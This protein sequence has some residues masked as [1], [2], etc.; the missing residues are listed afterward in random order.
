MRSTHRRRPLAGAAVAVLALLGAGLP[1]TVASAEKKQDDERADLTRFYRQK[2][3]WSKCEGMEVPRDL[4]CGKIT[5]PLDYAR[6]TAGT[7]DLAVAPAR[8]PAAP[9][10]PAGVSVVRSAAARP[11][12]APAH[13]SDLHMHQLFRRLVREEWAPE[14]D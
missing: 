11:G 3:T 7:L 5:V 1:A 6:P 9:P 14:V 4:R 13:R 8:G 2:I 12:R 10:P